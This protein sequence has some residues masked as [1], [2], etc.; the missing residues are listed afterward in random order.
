MRDIW[1]VVH[2]VCFAVDY[3]D[4]TCPKCTFT[5]PVKI[6]SAGHRNSQLS[7]YRMPPCHRAAR[8]GSTV[9]IRDNILDKLCSSFTS[10]AIPSGPFPFRVFMN[11]Q[12][13]TVSDCKKNIARGSTDPGYRVH[14]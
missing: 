9:I 6:D 4:T 7:S 3:L 1:Q 13:R 11:R 2:I 10:E 8:R 14:N 12:I 5:T